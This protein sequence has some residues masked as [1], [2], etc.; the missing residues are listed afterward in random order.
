MADDSDMMLV[1]GMD[2]SPMF[3]SK[4]FEFLQEVDTVIER[5][6]LQADPTYA[7][8]FG[9]LLWKD[10]HLKG[11]ALAKFLSKMSQHWD[12]FQLGEVQDRFEDAVSSEIGISP[13]TV[14]KYTGMWENL[15][16]NDEIPEDVRKQLF[17]KPIRSLLLLNAA[18]RDGD[19][20]DWEG[21]AGAST[22]NEIRNLVREARGERTS[23]SSAIRIILYPSGTLVM[24]KG[25]DLSDT[26]I[27]ELDVDQMRKS[28]DVNKA[29]TRIIDRAGI[30]WL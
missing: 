5:S 7:F 9:R 18:A 19:D 2:I 21:I 28:P 26:I 12:Q 1:G 16:E 13:Q 24:R 3:T 29:I 17:G 6:V 23:S 25:S 8:N 20:L 30:L 27:G 14:R 15:F 10:G 11:L 4:D 22:G